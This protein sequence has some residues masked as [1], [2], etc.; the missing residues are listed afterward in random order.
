MAIGQSLLVKMGRPIF[1]G[2]Q[3]LLELSRSDGPSLQ[4]IIF[5][6]VPSKLNPMGNKEK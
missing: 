2:S 1:L 6:T 4:L 3:V 5:P